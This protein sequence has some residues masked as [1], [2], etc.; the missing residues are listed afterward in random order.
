MP[1][2]IPD[3]FVLTTVLSGFAFFAVVWFLA[4]RA[5]YSL[6]LSDTARRT[7]SFLIA[8]GLIG[9]FGAISLLGKIGFWAANPLV[10]PHILLGFL[11]LFVVLKRLYDLPLVQKIADAIPQHWIIGIQTYR[12]MGYGF[13]ILY[14]MHLLPAA[15]AFPAGIGDIIVGVSAPIVALVYFLKK[16]YARKLAILWNVIGIADLVIAIGIGTLAY[17]RPFQILA[18]EVS[19]DLFSQFP[20]VLIP[21]FAVPLSALLHFF[22][23]RVIVKKNDVGRSVIH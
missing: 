18:T 5:I 3:S 15:F 8:A 7:L 12:V 13:L 9:W 14:Q 1:S 22:S 10:A 2:A 4:H 23:L 20:L 11:F 21:L 19:T 6:S 16:S 17:P